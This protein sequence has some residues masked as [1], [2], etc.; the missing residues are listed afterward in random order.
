MSLVKLLTVAGSFQ[1][2]GRGVVVIP[3][4]P[5]P[6]AG[7]KASSHTVVIVTPGGGSREVEARLEVW[8]FNIPDAAVAAQ[9]GEGLVLSF[10]ALTKN[11]VPIG[12]RIMVPPE[13]RDVICGP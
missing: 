12:S 3:N 5:P 10:P 13:L 7:W 6:A 1:L 4:L 2:K 11:E 9:H 8:H